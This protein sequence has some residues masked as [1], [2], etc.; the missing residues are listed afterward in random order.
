MVQRIFGF[1]NPRKNTM[2]SGVISELMLYPVKSLQGISV[3]ESAVTEQ[4]LKWDRHWMIVN[5]E[6]MFATQRH[7]S[8]MATIQTKITDQHLILST[9]NL[10]D[11]Y[12]EL[13]SEELQLA[14]RNVKVWK[15]ECLAVDE[16]EEVSQWLTNVLGQWR[17]QNLSLVRMASSSKR[18]V[19]DKYTNGEVNTTLFSDGYP[20]LIT[21]TDSLAELNR[22][23]NEQNESSV[24]MS[25]FRANIVIDNEQQAKNHRYPQ[26]I[27][28]VCN[29]LIIKTKQGLK[30]TLCKPCERCKVPSIDQET[31]E[32]LSAQQPLKTLF[33]IDNV[34]K[35]GAFFG[36]NAVLSHSS[37]SLLK[38]VIKVGD[39]VEFV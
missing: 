26:F 5:E 30:F 35:K 9:A 39:T 1:F 3:N 17:G 10:A 36:E 20:F 13:E 16:G 27:E 31:G 21:T 23:L 34:D 24:P 7:F 33:R 22:C 37:K 38:P 4:G 2:H 8:K 25:R 28:H 14:K 29:E 18:I 6:G 12:I 15:S 11:C 32:V 19:S